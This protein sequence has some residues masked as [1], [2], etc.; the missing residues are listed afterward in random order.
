MTCMC[1]ICIF[2]Y[3]NKIYNFSFN[4]STSR[5]VKLPAVTEVVQK[6][7]KKSVSEDSDIKVLEED[8]TSTNELKC[9]TTV[10][11]AGRGRKKTVTKKTSLMKEVK[12]EEPEEKKPTLTVKDIST[13]I[14]EDMKKAG[15]KA[16][17]KQVKSSEKE[18]E[19]EIKPIEQ[20]IVCKQTV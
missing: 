19:K 1:K 11:S 6:V 12:V 17:V 20:P 14:D 2:T 13:L 10:C 7:S 18:E 9:K 15:D 3:F 5:A 16:S 8:T 4:F